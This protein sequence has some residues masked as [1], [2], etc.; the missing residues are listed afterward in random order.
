[1]M[2]AVKKTAIFLPKEDRRDRDSCACR[3][4]AIVYAC[5]GREP[6]EKI[7]IEGMAPAALELEKGIRRQGERTM[8]NRRQVVWGAGG[9]ALLVLTSSRNVLATDAAAVRAAMVDRARYYLKASNWAPGK[10]LLSV[11][12]E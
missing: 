8:I 10:P 9:G 7:P 11:T 1:M 5:G 2:V 3:G 4:S 12:Q 6:D